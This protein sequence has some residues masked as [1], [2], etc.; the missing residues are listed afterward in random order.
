MV[1][2]FLGCLALDH[3]SSVVL[4]SGSARANIYEGV[5]DVTISDGESNRILNLIVSASE[6]RCEA[7]IDL[8]PEPAAALL[9]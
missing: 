9:W 5:C 1:T 7:N 8:A 4:L 2:V 6:K 3:R